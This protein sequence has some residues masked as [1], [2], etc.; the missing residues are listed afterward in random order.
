MVSVLP[1]ARPPCPGSGDPEP[2][3]DPPPGPFPAPLPD[4]S[5][6]PHAPFPIG[7]TYAGA[8]KMKVVE[9]PNTFG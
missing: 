7:P 2:L 3:P 5:P 1:P 4:P 9:E 6:P 8:A